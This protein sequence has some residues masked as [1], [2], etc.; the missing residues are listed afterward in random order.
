MSV[1]YPIKSPIES[2]CFGSLQGLLLY[3]CF[4]WFAQPVY[5]GTFNYLSPLAL[6]NTLA[7]TYYG[8]GNCLPFLFPIQYGHVLGLEEH[9][10]P[11]LALA[12]AA[13]W[14]FDFFYRAVS[15]FLNET[16]TQYPS[17]AT[18]A[19]FR[20]SSAVPLTV[21]GLIALALSYYISTKYSLLTTQQIDTANAGDNILVLSLRGLLAV[22]VVAAAQ[23]HF[24]RPTVVRTAL[25]LAALALVTPIAFQLA[26]RSVVYP[27][28]VIILSMELFHRGSVKRNHIIA[29]LLFL[30][31][32]WVAVR[33]IK[34]TRGSRVALTRENY[35][36]LA[37]GVSTTS[38]RDAGY[39]LAGLD[40][41]AAIWEQ[42][43][44]LGN[45]P[46]LGRHALTAFLGQIPRVLWPGKDV[47]DSK[48]LI[49]DA[50]G[51][52]SPEDQIMTPLPSALADGGIVGGILL[53]SVLGG[54]LCL[55]Q[56][57]VLR[58]RYGLVVYF[59]SISYLF[60]FE[61]SGVAYIMLYVR[62]SLL[63]W[64]FLL[65]VAA[66]LGRRRRFEA[67]IGRPLQRFSVSGD[68]SVTRSAVPYSRMLRQRSSGSA[69]YGC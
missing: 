44:H 68:R 57:V 56:H 18:V 22:V 31:I 37:S 42:Q 69:T 29:L 20:T 67:N 51:M 43:I 35:S 6:F 4:R 33:L 59:C 41:P 7:F 66:V 54:I 47:P 36:V 13:A 34:D 32:G 15:Q 64:P 63:V 9:Y 14:G 60:W 12:A 30:V 50:Y 40:F 26:S 25:S 10:I 21:I 62:F 61:N 17:T 3:S 5:V 19:D 1:C 39:R 46:L 65:A 58:A 28:G 49:Y 38:S 53:A 48:G 8:P 16:R 23:F 45:P 11:V 27:L 52:N 2:F 55:L 24:R